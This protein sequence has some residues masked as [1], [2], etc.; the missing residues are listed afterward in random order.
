[1]GKLSLYR[2]E[3]VGLGEFDKVLDNQNMQQAKSMIK[4]A[5]IT[6]ADLDIILPE[7]VVSE[8]N[9]I[10]DAHFSGAA[11]FVTRLS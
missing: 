3:I 7:F 5:I 10:Q 2:V 9:M 6:Y 8:R 4:G 11:V 1:M